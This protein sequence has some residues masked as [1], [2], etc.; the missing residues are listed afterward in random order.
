MV[1]DGVF[2]D[3]VLMGFI[4]NPHFSFSQEKLKSYREVSSETQVTLQQVCLCKKVSLVTPYALGGVSRFLGVKFQH[5]PC[6][7]VPAA[8]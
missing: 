8:E 7:S 5:W 4:C 1:T 2:R 3:Y 6:D